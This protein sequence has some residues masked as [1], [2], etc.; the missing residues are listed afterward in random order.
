MYRQRTRSELNALQEIGKVGEKWGG[1][2]GGVG[3]ITR[4]LEKNANMLEKINSV[5]PCKRSFQLLK[6]QSHAS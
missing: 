4:E 5:I 2:G 3:K 1:G 6:A